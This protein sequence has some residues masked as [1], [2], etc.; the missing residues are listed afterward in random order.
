MAIGFDAPF[1][2]VSLKSTG[3]ANDFAHVA[4]TDDPR[5]LPFPL[6]EWEWFWLEFFTERNRPENPVRE[7][8]MVTPWERPIVSEEGP[9]TVLSFE[10]QDVIKPGITLEQ[11]YYL[12]TQAPEFDVHYVIRNN[13]DEWL[14]G[15]Y[16]MV[17]FP[18]FMNHRAAVA[19]ETSTA[20][21]APGE[22]FS[23]YFDE[24]TALGENEY[25]LIRHDVFPQ[26]RIEELRGSVTIE[27][28]GKQF[29]LTSTFTPD[30][31]INH[32]YSAHTNKPVYLTSHL[33]VF[34]NDIPPTQSRAVVVH[35]EIRVEVKSAVSRDTWG[36]VKESRPSSLPR[37]GR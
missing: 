36:G 25:I 23:S 37:P 6:G 9:W 1:G 11:A 8:V 30:E 28:P 2:I 5:S 17:G 14:R 3:Q 7:K 10:K 27:E 16:V 19:V 15:P 20:R 21:H 29:I 13:T 35:N 32:V 18:G 12:N 24:S 22:E 33:H 26:S 31:S 34:F 4:A